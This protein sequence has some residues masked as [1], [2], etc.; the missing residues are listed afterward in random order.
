MNLKSE[1][2]SA[3]LLYGRENEEWDQPGEEIVR[4]NPEPP[5]TTLT[6]PNFLKFVVILAC[7]LLTLFFNI[8]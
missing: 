2:K 7:P 4:L 1:H 8:L 5:P 6:A 3:L